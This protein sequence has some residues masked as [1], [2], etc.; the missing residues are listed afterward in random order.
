MEEVPRNVQIAIEAS[1][2]YLAREVKIAFGLVLVLIDPDRYLTDPAYKKQRKTGSS[3]LRN[4]WAFSEQGRKVWE[5]EMPEP[6]DYYHEILQSPA[7]AAASFSGY[8]C[9]L[10]PADGRILH[11]TFHK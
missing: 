5:A 2:P 8:T 11:R 6:N 3:A 10:D 4:L 1:I 7:L 9:E